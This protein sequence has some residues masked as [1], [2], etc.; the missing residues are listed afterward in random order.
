VRHIPELEQ[1]SD[2][3]K[4]HWAYFDPTCPFSCIKALDQLGA[5]LAIEGPFDGV[6]GFSQGALLAIAYMLR[7]Q[8]QNPQGAQPFK[9]AVLIAWTNAHKFLNWLR[10]E[11]I[12]DLA[13]PPAG[14]APINIPTVAILGEQDAAS[15]NDGTTIKL[16]N[17]K[18]L[19]VFVHQGGHE[20][21]G[22]NIPDSL[23]GSVK[24]IRRAVF[25]AQHACPFVSG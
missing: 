16:F 21:P 3:N 1:I 19:S 11:A 20:T 9:C 24:V 12:Q 6:I 18:T 8:Q 13:I 4:P 5:Y 17:E 15:T 14:G 2:P 23:S 7:Y 10:A 22:P 25:Q